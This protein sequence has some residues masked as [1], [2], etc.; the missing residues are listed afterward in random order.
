[1]SHHED[2]PHTIARNARNGL[3]LFAIYVVL[4]GGF[5]LMG[6]L[7]PD[8]MAAEAWGGVNIAIVYGFGLI[9]A[10]LVLALIYM[11][12]CRM[13]GTQGQGDEGTDGG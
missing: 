2:H 11:A 3:A 7:R 13:K 9:F 1:M 12:L 4:Y 6:T 5:M 10:A 8:L